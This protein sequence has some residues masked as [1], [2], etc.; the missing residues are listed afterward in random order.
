M[1]I[2][3]ILD[4]NISFV[5]GY[6]SPLEI[7]SSQKSIH[8]YLSLRWESDPRPRSYQERALPLSHLG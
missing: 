8:I 6:T 3:I 1:E 7:Y 5:A 2:S 4:S